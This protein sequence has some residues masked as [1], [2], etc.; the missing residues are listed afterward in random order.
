MQLIS[1]KKFG[2]CTVACGLLPFLRNV[3][4][5]YGKKLKSYAL[6]IAQRSVANL[7]LLKK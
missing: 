5:K 1:H 7:N 3:S 4:L 2:M 6:F